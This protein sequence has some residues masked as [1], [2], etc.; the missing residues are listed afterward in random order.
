MKYQYTKKGLDPLVAKTAV[1]LVRFLDLTSLD[2]PFLEA[3]QACQR[4]VSNIFL[5]NLGYG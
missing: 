2:K 4:I 1:S 5:K 3:G